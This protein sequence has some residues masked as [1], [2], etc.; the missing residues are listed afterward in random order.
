MVTGLEARSL[1]ISGGKLF[2]IEGS[3]LKRS[4]LD[5]TQ[6]TTV[7]SFVAAPTDI[8]VDADAG[9]YYAGF[10]GAFS[11]SGSFSHMIYRSSLAGP[12]PA[13]PVLTTSADPHSLAFGGGKLYWLEDHSIWF[14]NPD[15]SGK[16]RLMTFDALPLDLSLDAAAGYAYISFDG[17]TEASPHTFA[18]R[19][20][21]GSPFSACTPT[22]S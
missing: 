19:T 8:Y 22:I 7:A 21:G 16:T 4:N 18:C 20:P 15:G 10:G 11:G 9:F 2:W 1:S 5:G 17:P 13:L 12:L 14:A 6:Q 3:E